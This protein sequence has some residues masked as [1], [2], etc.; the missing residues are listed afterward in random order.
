MDVR[1][2]IRRRNDEED[3]QE[4]RDYATSKMESLDRY[5]R[6]ARSIEVVLDADH[7]ERSCEVIAHLDRGAPLVVTAK[8]ADVHASIDLAHDKIEKVLRRLKERLD[9]RRHAPAP[10]PGVEGDID[11]PTGDSE[12]QE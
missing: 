2:S 4:I 6:H 7:L 9:D 10:T 12:E 3:E 5:N 8:H 1:I 11:V